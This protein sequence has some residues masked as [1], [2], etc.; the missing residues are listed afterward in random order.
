MCQLGKLSQV[1]RTSST[2]HGSVVVHVFDEKRVEKLQISSILQL[3][4]EI[5]VDRTFFS[6]RARSR[7]RDEPEAGEETMMRQ[8]TSNAAVPA[9]VSLH[10]MLARLRF[11]AVR[12]RMLPRAA[13]ADMEDEAATRATEAQEYRGGT[14]SPASEVFGP[15]SSIL[16]FYASMENKRLYEAEY[17]VFEKV[18]SQD[19]SEIAAGAFKHLSYR[20]ILRLGSK[21][22]L[23]HGPPSGD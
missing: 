5:T 15:Q 12:Q 4:S 2:G 13:E 10:R 23:F 22:T 9:A 6:G 20:T 19:P 1:A 18:G 21:L 11:L 8:P 16:D 14:A 17:I 3:V 7:F